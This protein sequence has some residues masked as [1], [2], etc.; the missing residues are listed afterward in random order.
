MVLTGA[1]YIL[2]CVVWAVDIRILWQEFFVLMPQRMSDATP[3]NTID[4]ELPKINGL[5]ALLEIC[6][7]YL[8]VRWLFWPAFGHPHI[9][10]T[11]THRRFHR[12][13]AGV[14]YLGA[15]AMVTTWFVFH[16]VR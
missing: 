5:T 13:V 6:C 3:S 11:A 7:W 1:M 4:V 12:P 16:H 10:L 8:I 2:S 14:C 15:A 9:N